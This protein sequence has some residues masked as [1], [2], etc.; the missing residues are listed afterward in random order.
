[1]YL[2]RLQPSLDAV[3]HS[4][5][6]SRRAGIAESGLLI[7]QMGRA[8][9]LRDLGRF[10]D[11][12]PLGHG[13]PQALRDAGYAVWAINAEN[14]LALAYA[15]LGRPD[16]AWRALTPLAPATADAALPA[17]MR[18]ARLL[19]LARLARDFGVTAVTTA[20]AQLVR[21]ATALI[22][23]E[24]AGRSHV[25]LR[26]A[27]ELARDLPPADALAQVAAVEAEALARENHMLAAHAALLRT[28]L[29]LAQGQ[30]G[31]ALDAADTL[32]A[33]CAANAW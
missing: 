7:E 9:G 22:D 2:G 4:I 3:V 23:A 18:A 15:W 10:A 11:Y 31:A 19:T 27:L 16:L 13:L 33:L 32:L 26:V 29:L 6:C 17:V 8:G 12:L 20:P 1:M 21:E 24:G 25:R 30:Q 14:D 5:A 28:R